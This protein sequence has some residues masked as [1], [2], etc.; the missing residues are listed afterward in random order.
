MNQS[1]N[2]IKDSIQAGQPIV[3]IVSYEEKR[4]ESFL[5]KLCQQ[6]QKNQNLYTWDSHNGFGGSE[7]RTAGSKYPA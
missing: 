1:I 7:G 6:V 4:V 3:Q 2:Q 5:K